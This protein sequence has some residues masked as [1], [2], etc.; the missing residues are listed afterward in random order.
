MHTRTRTLAH[1]RVH[2]HMHAICVHVPID[3]GRAHMHTRMPKVLLTTPAPFEI[4]I[5][6]FFLLLFCFTITSDA[7]IER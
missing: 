6:A 3:C 2:L 7:C 5:L 1:T 4:A